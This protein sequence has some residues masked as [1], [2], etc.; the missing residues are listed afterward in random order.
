MNCRIHF[1]YVM[2]K[3]LRSKGFFSLDESLDEVNKVRE[4][5]WLTEFLADEAPL[6]EDKQ[7]KYK[8]WKNKQKIIDFAFGP[9]LRSWI[10]RGKKKF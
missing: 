5:F 1:V 6:K 4:N 2:F 7:T 10:E 9:D 8:K 3:Y